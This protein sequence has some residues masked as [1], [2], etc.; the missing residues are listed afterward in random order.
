MCANL[1]LRF[2]WTVSI[3]PENRGNLFTADFQIYLSPVIAAAEILRR[4]M[5]GFLRV[6]N[7]HLSIHG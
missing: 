4:S 5:W 1:V 7:E 2:L 3:I 6:E